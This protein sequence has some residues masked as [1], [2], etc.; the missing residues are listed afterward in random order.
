VNAR[1]RSGLYAL[2]FGSAI[3]GCAAN[4]VDLTAIKKLASAASTAAPAMDAVA[5][6]YLAS[7][8]RFHAL[9]AETRI[10]SHLLTD[11]PPGAIPTPEP[12]PSPADAPKAPPLQAIPASG[13]PNCLQVTA[14]SQRWLLEN[15]VVVGFIGAL[16][17]I[18]NVNAAQSP[19]PFATAAAELKKLGVLHNDAVAAVA[20][21][22]ANAL[23]TAFLRRRGDHDIIGFVHDAQDAG[24]PT[25]VASLISVDGYYEDD[26]R[27]ERPMLNSRETQLASDLWFVYIEARKNGKLPL[28]APYDPHFSPSTFTP[29]QINALISSAGHGGD[30]LTPAIRAERYRA[31]RL[32]QKLL[33]LRGSWAAQSQALAQD[34]LAAESY[35]ATIVSLNKAEQTIVTSRSGFP[36]LAASL[37]PIMDD[38]QSSASSLSAATGASATSASPK[39]TSK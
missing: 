10:G 23:A 14:S 32:R 12:T 20:G 11:P 28:D 7:C 17:T 3:A 36:A 8:Q 34:V 13:D 19:A 18:A 6:D 35:R 21:D 26:L 38:F 16:A 30:A 37:K 22:F 29:E 33:D 9:Q 25:F 15:K 27:A 24:W 39:P 1:W 2:L 31:D 4:T 5:N